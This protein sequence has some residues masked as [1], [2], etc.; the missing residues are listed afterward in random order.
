MLLLALLATG[1]GTVDVY[2]DGFAICGP[3]DRSLVFVA[4][5]FTGEQVAAL[6][7]VDPLAIGDLRTT[8]RGDDVPGRLTHD[9]STLGAARARRH[10]AAA[11]GLSDLYRLRV[12]DVE[13]G[14][15]RHPDGIAVTVDGT[16][17]T[18]VLL[19]HVNGGR[20]VAYRHHHSGR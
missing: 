13:V 14:V 9:L 16:A 12:F 6:L 4:G 2:D 8:R 11:G 20:P 17:A 7:G 1:I 18:G 10:L 19:V 5:A 3:G 15:H